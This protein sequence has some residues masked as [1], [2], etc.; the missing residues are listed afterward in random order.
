MPA[1]AGKRQ[2]GRPQLGGLGRL[3]A[4]G[5][6][7]HTAAGATPEF[8]ALWV[9]A[10]HAG[11]KNNA[12]VRQLV[13]D[14][15]AG[16]FNALIVQ[17]RKRGD[18]YYN[19]RFEPKAP[20]I[21]AGYD[22]LADLISQAH[23]GSPRLE[24]HAWIVTFPVW[25][26]QTA[27]S[28]PAHPFNLHPDWLMKNQAGNTWDGSNHQFDPGHPAVQTHLCNVAMDLVSRYD[29]DGFHFDY[30]RYPGTDWGYNEVALARFNAQQGRVGQPASTD[31][32][33]LQF[34]RDQVTAVVRRVYLSAIARKPQVK[35]SAATITWAPGITTD[36]EWTGSAA[37]ARVLQDWRAWMQEGLLDLN[38]PMAY[39]RQP[40]NAADWTAWSQFAKNHRY[41]R[42][43]ALGA[44]IYLNTLTDALLQMRS[45]RTLTASGYRADGVVGYSY[46]VSSTDATRA[47]F[48][49]ALVRPSGLDTNATPLFAEAVSPPLMPWKSAP[50]LG[51]LKGLARHAVSGAALDGA[52]IG[53]TGPV[54]RQLTADANGFFGAV[55]LPAGVYTLT[56]AFPNLI[57]QTQPCEVTAGVV[58][59]ADFSLWPPPGDLF[60]TQLD[61][62]AGPS[63]AIITWQTPELAASEVQYGP[64]AGAPNLNLTVNHPAV[65]WRH[66]VRLPNLA[67]GTDYAFRVVSSTAASNY[68]TSLRFFR[69]AGELI[70]DNPA[71]SYTGGWTLGNSSAGRYGADYQYAATVSGAATATAA[72][73][74]LI[75][76]PGNYDVWVWY[77]AGSNRSAAAP[78]VTRYDG[79]AVT[80]YVNQTTSGGGW[81]AVALG[82]HFAA[83]A[84]GALLLQ[85]NTGES[86]KIVVADAVRW[87]YAAGQDPPP[88]GR[89]PEWW[90]QHYFGQQVSGAADADGD[91]YSNAD[92]F[93]LGLDPA[94]ARSC[95][96][97]LAVPVSSDRCQL[98]F[99]PCHADR[100]YQLL[101]RSSFAEGGWEPVWGALLWRE[102][103]GYGTLIDPQ[104]LPGAQFYRLRV[105]LP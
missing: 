39:F 101:R 13:A 22:P 65:G 87:V 70:L 34:R 25:N 52:S 30:V 61:V 91:G 56:G 64:K 78:F 51:H 83:G 90:A 104:P 63:E 59:N 60:V 102:D 40:A 76:T 58:A 94:D 72:F 69:T 37:H 103:F 31:N 24:V 71:A 105:A 18:A 50:V 47:D 20:D 1:V 48:L 98:R 96:E 44:G 7:A 49:N 15:R 19:S 75:T 43:V 11:F 100:V 54:A 79:G 53:L 33:W 3:V 80:S 84:N 45:T 5:A 12:E 26:S 23:S 88:A 97:L 4:L 85:N 35:V 41:R 6:V 55:D 62:A 27:P 99:W 2:T 93:V 86:G 73:I 21:A 17:A 32:A 10:W 92:E 66:S 95:L 46:A 14:A 28:Q 68:V 74:P 89:V 67:R 8:R 16:H 42:H 77:P 29:L 38:V 82:R 81:R 57:A 9:D 36:A